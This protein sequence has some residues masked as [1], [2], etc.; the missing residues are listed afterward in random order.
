MLLVSIVGMAL[1]SSEEANPP[2]VLGLSFEPRAACVHAEVWKEGK[3]RSTE[4]CANPW[5]Y[6]ESTGFRAAVG[7]LL[8]HCYE[9]RRIPSRVQTWRRLRMTGSFFTFSVIGAP[10]GLTLWAIGGA[11]ARRAE[12][13]FEACLAQ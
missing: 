13:D 10:V 9:G 4:V 1:A 2:R 12:R 3:Y 6:E 11:E 8:E 7:E 5:N